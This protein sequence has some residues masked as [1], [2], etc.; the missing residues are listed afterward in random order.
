MK[1]NRHC[2]KIR[3]FNRSEVL[4]YA[5]VLTRRRP[6]REY[7]QYLLTTS[8]LLHPVKE[9]E[10]KSQRK[11]FPYCKEQNTVT[12]GTSNTQCAVSHN[13]LIVIDRQVVREIEQCTNQ[14]YPEF[15][16]GLLVWTRRFN[17]GIDRFKL[18]FLCL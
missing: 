3:S 2:K 12:M 9:F 16:V 8:P 11:V 17:T 5:A 18:I 6:L 13:G 7:L 4:L 15:V 10:L 1:L 14:L